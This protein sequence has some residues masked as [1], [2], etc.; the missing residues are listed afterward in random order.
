MYVPIIT[1]INTQV[2]MNIS[3][4]NNELYKL[5]QQ[6]RKH[7]KLIN[8]KQYLKFYVKYQ[9]RPPIQDLNTRR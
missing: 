6:V 3:Y 7:N 8:L 4:I 2:S 1:L 9:Y 5:F